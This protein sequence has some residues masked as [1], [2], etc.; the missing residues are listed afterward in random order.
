MRVVTA[1]VS[2]VA[3][4]LQT[5]GTVTLED[6]ADEFRSIMTYLSRYRRIDG[7]AR[8]LEVGTGIGWFPVLCEKNG[9][10]CKG[11]E[12]SRQLVDYGKEV[13]RRHGIDPDIELGNIEETDIGENRYDV[14]VALSV[15]EHVEDWRKGIGRIFR[16]L[17]PDGVFYFTSTNKFSLVSGEYNFPLYG[18]LPDRWRYALRTRRQGE[19]IMNLGID[20]N[21]F[22][23][24]QLR[25]FFRKTGFRVIHDAVDM[26][27]T[28][29]LAHPAPWK[30]LVLAVL[31][32]VPPLKHLYLTFR[33]TTG[34]IC[35][36]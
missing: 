20:F 15:F 9:I 22:R 17:K 31:K 10:L 23:F 13:G 21:Q 27:A 2:D 14:V 6:K 5:M 34:F 18:W 12:I 11:I 7:R 3:R 25:R 36:K 1:E 35:I 26:L 4:Y 28:D 24:P 19:D 30:K 8:L 33:T 32:G 29:G 16:A